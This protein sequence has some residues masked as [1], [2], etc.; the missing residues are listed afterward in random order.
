[1]NTLRAN[2]LLGTRLLKY[3]ARRGKDGLGRFNYAVN[4]FPE[5]NVVYCETPKVGCTKIKQLILDGVYNK[6]VSGRGIH[7]VANETMLSPEKM[8]YRQFCKWYYDSSYVKTFLFIRDPAERLAS[9]YRDKIA[10]SEDEGGEASFEPERKRIF[11]WCVS[12]GLKDG[13]DTDIS[14]I[15]FLNFCSTADLSILNIHW[16]PQSD[17]CWQ[18]LLRHTHIYD[19][20]NFEFGVTHLLKDL[21][22]PSD[23]IASNLRKRTNATTGGKTKAD[24]AEVSTPLREK[25]TARYSDDYRLLEQAIRPESRAV[26]EGIT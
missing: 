18:N 23:W 8:G 7:F 10:R 17:I 21:G 5:N 4:P 20:R 26:L 1:M 24:L 25:L 9:A 3:Q 14:F 2:A 6:Q 11:D 16:A 22:L 13:S 15:D 19:Y 12:A